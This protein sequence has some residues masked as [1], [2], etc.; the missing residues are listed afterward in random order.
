MALQQMLK[1]IWLR[2]SRTFELHA[3]GELLRYR[4]LHCLAARLC[5]LVAIALALTMLPGSAWLRAL[6]LV[7]A[8]AV[9]LLGRYL[10]FVGVV[11]KNMAASYL[12]EERAA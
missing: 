3:T 10:F 1:F 2:S 4:L 11:P 7:A 9:E 5:G 12:R 8:I 6:C